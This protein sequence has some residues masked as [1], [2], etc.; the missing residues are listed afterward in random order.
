MEVSS[1]I[2]DRSVPR[3]GGTGGE[4]EVAQEIVAEEEGAPP[5]P[6]DQ[7]EL[8]DIIGLYQD[9]FPDYTQLQDADYDYDAFE[10]YNSFQGTFED[11]G[12][13]GVQNTFEY[14]DTF[15]DYNEIQDTLDNTENDF[16]DSEIV[17][18]NT[19]DFDDYEDTAGGGAE[20]PG[21]EAQCESSAEAEAV[22]V[23]D[24]LAFVMTGEEDAASTATIV[25]QRVAEHQDKVNTMV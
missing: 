14:S 6:R 12:A 24:S 8:H 15:Q 2:A 3:S 5:L 10:E 1:N 22:T 21:G 4:W 7:E 19:N 20:V 13:A 25:L 18:E 11:S 17:I 9:S 16:D 23:V